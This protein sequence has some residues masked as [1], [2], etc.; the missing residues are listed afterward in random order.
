M[1]IVFGLSITQSVDSLYKHTVYWHVYAIDTCS[2]SVE[3]VTTINYFSS[4]YGLHCLHI[5]TI[6]HL[7][8]YS[9]PYLLRIPM[10]T[11]L[12]VMI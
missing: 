6:I 7:L 10:A 2:V 1:T 5:G 12:T 3:N 9:M 8:A 4:I 11:N